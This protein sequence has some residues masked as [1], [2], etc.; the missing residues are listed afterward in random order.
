MEDSD[1]G[2]RWNNRGVG[3]RHND[4]EWYEFVSTMQ[5]LDKDADTATALA[6]RFYWEGP[7]PGVEIALDDVR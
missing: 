1:I 7:E 5:F 3:G 6:R 2:K 4:G